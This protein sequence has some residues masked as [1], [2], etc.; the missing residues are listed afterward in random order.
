MLNRIV[1]V[2]RQRPGP[3]SGT[4]PMLYRRCTG[5]SAGRHPGGKTGGMVSLN[6]KQAA[7]MEV[8]RCQRFFKSD[9]LRFRPRTRGTPGGQFQDPATPVSALPWPAIISS[10]SALLGVALGGFLTTR[11]QKRQWARGQQI[12]ACAAIVVES[13]PRAAFAARAVEARP[14]C[15]LGAVE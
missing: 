4:T 9:P 7:R 1:R 2:S 11:V 13:T 14:A 5:D 15:R 3:D 6:A 12:E 8:S 10:V